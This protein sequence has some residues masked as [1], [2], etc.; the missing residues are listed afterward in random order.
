MT[1]VPA[2]V[3]IDKF[4]GSV[5]GRDINIVKEWK[6]KKKKEEKELKELNKEVDD[7]YGNDW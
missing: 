6:E 4:E 2:L 7:L 1:R 3:K 5:I